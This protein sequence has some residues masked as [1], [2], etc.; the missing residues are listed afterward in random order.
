M[1]KGV[2]R[3]Q[4]LASGRHHAH[5][6]EARFALFP[7]FFDDPMGKARGPKEPK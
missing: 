6:A 1:L 2:P 5:A 3:Q 7:P 4:M